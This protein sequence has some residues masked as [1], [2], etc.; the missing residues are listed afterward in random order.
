MAASVPPGG[1]WPSQSQ[2]GRRSTQ[3]TRAYEDE[4]DVEDGA[5]AVTDGRGGG[6]GGSGA[7]GGSW[8]CKAVATF[9]DALPIETM[10]Q[11]NTRDDAYY[12]A[13]SDCNSLM[14]TTR[15]LDQAGGRSRQ[16]ERDCHVT[17]C[18]QW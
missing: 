4:D 8:T 18:D 11:G 3:S 1:T 13:F 5:S 14:T 12:N 2:P 17:E 6:G 10:G 7:G 9:V 15:S 16:I